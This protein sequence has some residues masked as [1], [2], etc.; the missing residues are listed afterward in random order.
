MELQKMQSVQNHHFDELDIVKGL[1]IITVIL[2]HSFSVKYIDLSDI[3]W[4]N[5]TIAVI[6]SFNMQLF[7]VVSGF[8]FFHSKSLDVRKMFMSKIDRL[9]VPY[10]FLSVVSVT[11]KYCFPSLLNKEVGGGYN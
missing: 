10:I 1:A 8:L 5:T 3:A 4:C 7:F 6:K 2:E 9:L 11:A